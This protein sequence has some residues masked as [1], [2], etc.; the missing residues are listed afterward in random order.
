MMIGVAAFG[1]LAF[2]AYDSDSGIFCAASLGFA[3]VAAYYAV[4]GPRKKTRSKGSP[5]K[6]K[7]IPYSDIDARLHERA[8][9][10]PSGPNA[11]PTKAQRR[12]AESIGIT[13]PD[14][15]TAETATMIFDDAID[16]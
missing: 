16:Y 4:R 2:V 3:L 12:F 10:I 8:M 7:L 15:I 6:R 13:L 14:G 9:D 1:F 5:V 11:P